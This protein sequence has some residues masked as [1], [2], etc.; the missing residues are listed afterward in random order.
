M[1]PIIVVIEGKDNT[2]KSTLVETLKKNLPPIMEKLGRNVYFSRELGGSPNAEKIRKLLFSEDACINP[3]GYT[4]QLLA[5]ACRNEHITHLKATIDFTERDVLILDRYF[6]STF[7]FNLDLANGGAPSEFLY[8]MTDLAIQGFDPDLVFVLEV[9]E[10]ER[11]K[12]VAA[13]NKYL[14][15][16]DLATSSFHNAVGESYRRNVTSADMLDRYQYE[17]RFIN[18]DN[19]NPSEV[20][21][22]VLVGILEYLSDK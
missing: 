19:L 6:F 9:S 4:E 10:E 5:T 1:K 22:Y 2:G 16:N 13:V 15:K 11:L 21:V 18:T 14:D 3:N 20:Y 8:Q 12:R 17:Y 7:V